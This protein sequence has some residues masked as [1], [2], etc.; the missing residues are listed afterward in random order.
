LNRHYRPSIEQYHCP[1]RLDNNNN[2]SNNNNNYSRRASIQDGQAFT[3]V[4]G[5][6]LAVFFCRSKE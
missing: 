1:Y 6:L 4:I 2:N 5:G 3:R